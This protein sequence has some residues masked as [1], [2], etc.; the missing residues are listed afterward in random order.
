MQLVYNHGLVAVQYSEEFDKAIKM[1]KKVKAKVKAGPGLKVCPKCQT[2]VG[3]RTLVC[4]ECGHKFRKKSAKGARKAKVVEAAAVNAAFP[5]LSNDLVTTV[6]TAQELIRKCGS[7]SEAMR[8]V[9]TV[10]KTKS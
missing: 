3:V 5:V 4:G 6:L 9:S 8:L 10:G 1:A 7:T 2:T